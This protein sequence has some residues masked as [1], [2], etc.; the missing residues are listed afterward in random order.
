MKDDKAE[1]AIVEADSRDGELLERALKEQ[2]PS[3][4]TI[5]LKDGAEALSFFLRA[6]E[7]LR[8]IILNLTIPKLNA[9]EI[10]QRIKSDYRTRNIPVIVFASSQAK[11]D[12][13]RA[14]ELGVNSYVSKPPGEGEM[15][16]TIA[17]LGL[18][19]LSLNR[20]PS[21]HRH[22]GNETP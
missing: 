20:L 6:Y 11:Q 10:L 2:N 12:V 7:N 22:V 1:I 14:Y 17:R 13:K 19:W 18:Y 15:L 9:F 3:R 16:Q 5:I 4:K 21:S 8:V